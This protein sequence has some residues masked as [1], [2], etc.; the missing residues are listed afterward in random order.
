MKFL[1]ILPLSLLRMIQ[2][3]LD[4]AKITRSF[5][6]YRRPGPAKQMRAILGASKTG[7]IDPPTYKP[8]YWRVLR[9]PACSTR[10]GNAKSWTA[11]PRR[12]SKQIGCPMRAAFA[13]AKP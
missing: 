7:G 13:T 1:V 9:W 10:F 12:L 8:R 5:V 2:E 6:D 3:N 11:P 4:C